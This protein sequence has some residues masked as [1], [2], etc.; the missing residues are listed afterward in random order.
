MLTEGQDRTSQLLQ[1]LKLVS[2]MGCRSVCQMSGTTLHPL[3]VGLPPQQELRDP[4]VC[5]T[6]QG[7]RL[8]AR[9]CRRDSFPRLLDMLLLEAKSKTWKPAWPFALCKHSRTGKMPGH[10]MLGRQGGREGGGLWIT[11][12]LWVCHLDLPSPLGGAS[13]LQT[14]EQWNTGPLSLVKSA[15][16]VHQGWQCVATS[17]FHKAVA[18]L[19]DMPIDVEMLLEN[20]DREIYHKYATDLWASG[21]C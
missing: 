1:A 21:K 19:E 8:S 17:S 3:P 2:S 7:A 10:A 9:R 13:T 14:P 6:C 12:A 16:S 11:P 4:Q 20:I 18:E 5:L 15:T